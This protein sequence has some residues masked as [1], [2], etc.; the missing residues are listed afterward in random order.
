M[1]PSWQLATVGSSA[2]PVCLGNGR[3]R[4]TRNS[5]PAAVREQE[6]GVPA[7]ARAGEQHWHCAGSPGQ[8]ALCR[9]R[10]GPA[11]WVSL[12][13][14]GC[15]RFHHGTNRPPALWESGLS[16][17]HQPFCCQLGR[18][19]KR[20]RAHL[21]GAGWSSYNTPL[22]AGPSAS[23]LCPTAPVAFLARH[24]TQ[25]EPCTGTRGSL[26]GTTRA[27]GCQMHPWQVQ[28]PGLALPGLCL[29]F[30]AHRHITPP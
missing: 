24:K 17:R 30:P 9:G 28:G 2:D 29:L 26:E 21:P 22:P 23:C 25:T 1:W 8:E 4:T 15:S 20:G 14:W 27:C 6:G 7:E 5:D 13:T 3:P 16:E 12:L 19:G 10:L 18:D 11:L